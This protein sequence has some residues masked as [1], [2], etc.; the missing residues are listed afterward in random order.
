MK[1]IYESRLKDLRNR[2]YSLR[3]ELELIMKEQRDCQI[4][5]WDGPKLN[6]TVL[7][8]NGY[9]WKVK[10]FWFAG[11]MI[12]GL[13]FYRILGKKQYEYKSVY[14]YEFDN[15]LPWAFRICNL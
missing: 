1:D 8:R 13:H 7:C 11:D 10:D 5:L 4:A 3:R 15:F 6:S 2:E 9:L 14:T 12:V